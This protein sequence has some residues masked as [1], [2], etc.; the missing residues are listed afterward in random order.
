MNNVKLTLSSI[1]MDL[2]RVAIGINRKSFKMAE[3]F[4]LEAIAGAKTIQKKEVPPYIFKILTNLEKTL[5]ND[6]SMDVA[7]DSL[8]YSTLFRNVCS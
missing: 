3:I 5:A 1:S 6:N 8:M 4:K 7:E 2:L